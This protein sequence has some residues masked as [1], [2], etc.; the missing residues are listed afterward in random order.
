MTIGFF[1]DAIVVFSPK[2]AASAPDMSSPYPRSSLGLG[3][4][5]R[6]IVSALASWPIFGWSP[7]LFL[8]LLE[9]VQTSSQLALGPKEACSFLW[10]LVLHFIHYR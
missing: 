4:V 8:S 6:L 10:I 7:G 9:S 2:L 1:F 3:A 5:C